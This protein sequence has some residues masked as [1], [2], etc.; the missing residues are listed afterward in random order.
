YYA[1]SAQRRVTHPGVL[2]I[3]RGARQGWLDH[4]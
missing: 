4:S 3:T 1:I 2:A